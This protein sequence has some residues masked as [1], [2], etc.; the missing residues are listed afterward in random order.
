MNLTEVENEGQK[1]GGGG[2]G[3]GPGRGKK[4]Q[5]EEEVIVSPAGKNFAVRPG[6]TIIGKREKDDLDRLGQ[7]TPSPLL[8]QA[9]SGSG[10]WK[11]P[12]G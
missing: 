2:R 12:S 10:S 9:I 7:G 6:T 1:E 3:G 5:D 4:G 11:P 8:L